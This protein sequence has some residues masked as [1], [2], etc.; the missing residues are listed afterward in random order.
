MHLNSTKKYPFFFCYTL[1]VIKRLDEAVERSKRQTSLM[2]FISIKIISTVIITCITDTV[3]GK[4]N[5]GAFFLNKTKT[6][7][8]TTQ[9]ILFPKCL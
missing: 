8:I 5:G 2:E 9:K 7:I 6:D 4:S 1:A 3:P